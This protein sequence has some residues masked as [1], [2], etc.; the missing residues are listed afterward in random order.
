MK[1]DM[2][3]KAVTMRLRLTS[4]LRRLCLALGR[5]REEQAKKAGERAS[6]EGREQT[7]SEFS[8]DETE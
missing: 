5:G 8:T 6:E 3:P 7:G 1:T 2:S 4:E